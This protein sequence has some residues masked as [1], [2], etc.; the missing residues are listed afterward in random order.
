MPV[1]RLEPR[2]VRRVVPRAVSRFVRRLTISQWSR[3]RTV[4]GGASHTGRT[5]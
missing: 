4:L 3:R 2:A 1:Q 5:D